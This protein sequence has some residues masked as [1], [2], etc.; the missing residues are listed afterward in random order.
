MTRG[1]ALILSRKPGSEAREDRKQKAEKAFRA[2]DLPKSPPADLKGMSVARNT[3][4]R[5]M[6]I[7]DQ[8]PGQLYNSL[9]RGFLIGYCLAVQ[10]RQNALQLEADT[11]QGFQE[12]RFE[13]DDLLKVRAEARMATRLASDLEKQ[14][15]GTPKSRGG[16]NPEAKETTD[17]ME[18]EMRSIMALLEE[19]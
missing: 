11:Y 2:G 16:V 19:G 3:W 5:L 8:L 9:D 13:L 17:P 14:L 1:K 18:I 6:K 4:R 15:Y 10:A 7:H 12:G